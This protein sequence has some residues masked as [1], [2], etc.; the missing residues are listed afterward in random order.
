MLV[1][2][3]LCGKDP[4]TGAKLSVVGVVGEPLDEF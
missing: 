3:V 4:V 1:V 2:N